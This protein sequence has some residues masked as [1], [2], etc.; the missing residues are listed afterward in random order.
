MD[1]WHGLTMDDI[2]ALE[3][4]TK[5]ELDEERAKVRVTTFSSQQLAL[6]VV[7]LLNTGILIPIY[8]QGE[9]KGTA[10]LEE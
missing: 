1:K 9:L 6:Y 5:L 10:A 2:R 3:D 7:M 4:Q 8:F